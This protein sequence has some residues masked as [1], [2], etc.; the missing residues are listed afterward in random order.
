MINDIPG[1]T[2]PNQI[3]IDIP[4]EKTDT[5]DPVFLGIHFPQSV[6]NKH[7]AIV[8]A[9]SFKNDVKHANLADM[10]LKLEKEEKEIYQVTKT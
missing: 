4:K 7:F 1:G 6:S 8:Y 9:N 2:F 10:K 5:Y 3:C